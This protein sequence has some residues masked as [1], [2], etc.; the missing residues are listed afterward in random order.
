MQGQIFVVV[1]EKDGEYNIIA[2]AGIFYGACD[3]YDHINAYSWAVKP[4]VAR[5]DI[6]LDENL[7]IID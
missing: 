6:D 1:G 7:F 2:S 3:A 4:H 5:I